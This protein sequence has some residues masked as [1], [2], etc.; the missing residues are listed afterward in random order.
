M[1][2]RKREEDEG[3]VV[4]LLLRESR[5]RKF[6]VQMEVKEKN[7]QLKIVLFLECI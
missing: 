2:G 1:T 7:V 6:F 5:E 4:I 3:C